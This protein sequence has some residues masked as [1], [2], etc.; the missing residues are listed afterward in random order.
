MPIQAKVM[1]KG[2]L[3]E[4]IHVA[5]LKC[6]WGIVSFSTSAWR[7]IWPTYGQSCCS[8]ELCLRLVPWVC[9]AASQGLRRLN[10]LTAPVS[11]ETTCILRL[12]FMVW[13]FT[14]SIY[15]AHTQLHLF[16][17][18][19]EGKHEAKSDS[20]AKDHSSCYSLKCMTS[21]KWLKLKLKVRPIYAQV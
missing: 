1:I 8:A 17:S 3:D 2:G 13:N 21:G 19:W 12:D 16:L 5:D 11:L 14:C 7:V 6:L 4:N 18:W 9:C 20:W 10:Y 15:S